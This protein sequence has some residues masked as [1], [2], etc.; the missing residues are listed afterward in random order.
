MDTPTSNFQIYNELADWYEQKGPPAM[1]DRFLV[2]AADAALAAGDIAVAEHL[3]ERLLQFN[4]HHLLRAYTSFVQA[5]A[6]AEVQAHVMEL[7]RSYPPEA[8]R[9]LLLSLRDPEAPTE[10]R[11]PPTAPLIHIEENDF[12]GTAF[13]EPLP[14]RLKVYPMRH[15]VDQTEI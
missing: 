1:R 9:Q 11:L 8:A 12:E 10:R 6:A 2:L 13:L 4:P 7:Q 3:R 14:E 5:A 15:E